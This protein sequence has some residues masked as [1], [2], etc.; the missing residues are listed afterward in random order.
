MV[1]KQQSEFDL[2]KV[3]KY[4]SEL[5]GLKDI[6]LCLLCN[7]K[8]NINNIKGHLKWEYYKGKLSNNQINDE[9]ILREMPGFEEEKSIEISRL[10]EKKREYFKPEEVL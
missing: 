2:S 9:V 1:E 8:F 3:L 10:S 6:K 7:R 4:S 5:S